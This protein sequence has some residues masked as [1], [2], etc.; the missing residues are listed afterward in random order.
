MHFTLLSKELKPKKGLPKAASL[1]Y[2]LIHFDGI[3]YGI[4]FR[5]SI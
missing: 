4:S 2:K 5:M 1:S 3:S